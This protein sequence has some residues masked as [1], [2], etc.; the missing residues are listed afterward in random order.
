MASEPTACHPVSSPY[1]RNEATPWPS[2]PGI[3][4]RALRPDPGARPAQRPVDVSSGPAAEL[5]YLLVGEAGGVQR[6]VLSLLLRQGREGSKRLTSSQLVV[7]I[8]RV[9]RRVA[10][11]VRKQVK[12]Q[13]SALEPGEP[14]R[15]IDCDPT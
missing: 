14:V 13:L 15:L 6:I 5:R 7:E 9:A 10:A 8:E 4:R 2:L 1:K 3:C 11:V 12:P